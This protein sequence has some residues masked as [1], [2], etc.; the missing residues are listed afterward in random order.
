M[1][2]IVILSG[3]FLGVTTAHYL[4]RYVLPHLNSSPD[5][6]SYKITLV[7]TSMHVFFKVGAPRA[8]ISNFKTELHAPFTSIIEAF[9]AYPS[10]VF[11]FILGTAITLDA[12][13]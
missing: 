11:T 5:K 8:L 1:H 2:N 3:N 6:T 7:S 9:S 10:I 12:N 13:T 4:L